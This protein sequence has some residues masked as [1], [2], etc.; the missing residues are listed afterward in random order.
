M[1]IDSTEDSG[2]DQLIDTSSLV[3]I[4]FILIIFFLVT[5][6]FHEEE[7]DMAVNLP[8]TDLTLS[9]AVQVLVINI[10]D[11]GSYYLSDKRMDLDSL[12]AE[13]INVVSKNPDQKVLV[14]ADRN[15]L[16]GQVAQAIAACR[17]VGISEANIGYMTSM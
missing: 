4:M 16:H 11:D 6:S 13:L 2:G 10:R 14:R 5:T 7:T 9:S 17:R 12:N 1:R 8:E 3:D 15:A